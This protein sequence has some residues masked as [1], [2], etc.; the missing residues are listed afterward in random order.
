MSTRSTVEALPVYRVM[1]R[2]HSNPTVVI[3]GPNRRTAWLYVHTPTPIVLR[4]HPPVVQFLL[5][6]LRE[7][8]EVS[9]YTTSE[10]PVLHRSLR[11]DARM[12][13]PECLIAGRDRDDAWLHIYAA[14][15]GAV[16]LTAPV[17]E[18]LLE[19]LAILPA[20]APAPAGIPEVPSLVRRSG[21]RS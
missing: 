5:D 21:P 16:R 6:T 17:I 9:D 10:P 11:R 14:T 4:L 18:F 15:P 7:L 19:A 2:S 20:Y 1:L 3:A 13:Y 8:A 12:S